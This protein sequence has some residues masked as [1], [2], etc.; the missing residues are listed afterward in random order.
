MK[1]KVVEFLKKNGRFAILMLF[2]LEL[3]LTGLI[4][5]NKFDDAFFI[6]KVTNHSIISF[7]AERYN[8]WT[9]RVLIEFVLCLVLKTSKYLWI[10]LEAF[11]VAIARIFNFKNIY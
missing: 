10:L 5:P 7:V 11:M 1:E 8:N 3:I 4:T 9:S 6:E 2:I